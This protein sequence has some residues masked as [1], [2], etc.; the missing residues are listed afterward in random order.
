MQEVE[1]VSEFEVLQLSRHDVRVEIF[2][3]RG[4]RFSKLQA[5]GTPQQR[6]VNYV[7]RYSLNFGKSSRVRVRFLLRSS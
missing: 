6:R 7:V 5:Q 4:S 3:I 2:E 1:I